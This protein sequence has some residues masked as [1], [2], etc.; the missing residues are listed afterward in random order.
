MSTVP[1]FLDFTINAVLRPTFIQKLC[2]KLPSIV[3]F[4]FI[5]IFYQNCAFFTEWHKVAAFVWYSVKIHVI[6][7]V[8]FE[9]R[10]VDKKANLHENWNMQTLFFWILLPNFV[11]IDPY[12]FELYHF[13]VGAFFET[14][15]I[16]CWVGRC[17]PTFSVCF[18]LLLI[19]TIYKHQVK[20]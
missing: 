6:F 18:A 9:R 13:K 2:Y 11:K 20:S 1:N 17:S 12:N 5:Q 10:K 3:T 8:R 4:T 15:C 19:R 16:M 14:Q 7:G